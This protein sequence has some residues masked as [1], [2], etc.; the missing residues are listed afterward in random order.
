MSAIAGFILL[1]FSGVLLY[2]S[3][4]TL[5]LSFVVWIA[6]VP[7][8][9]VV[10]QKES[11]KGFI[12]SLFSGMIFFIGIFSW[13][14]EVPGYTY[15]HHA[16]LAVYLGS[17]IGI[18]G[19]VFSLINRRIGLIAA[20]FAAPF[21]W[22]ALEFIRSNFTFLALPWGLL[23]HSQ[24]KNPI[25]YQIASIT[26]TYGVSFLIVMVN[27]AIAALVLAFI[28][29]LKKHYS[30]SYGRR[31]KR[32][33]YAITGVGF[34]CLLLTCVYGYISVNQSFA[35]TPIKLAVVQGNI[36]QRKKWDRNYSKFIMQTYRDL[37][38]SAASKSPMMIVWPETATPGSISRHRGMYNKLKLMAA[39]ADAYLLF[40]SAQRA[41]F[42][43]H[44]TDKLKYTNSAFLIPPEKRK[45][46][47]QRYDKIRLFPFGEYLPYEETLPWSWINVPKMGAYV[48]GE[49]Y[50]ILKLD[51]VPF[52]ATICWE[53]MFSDLVRRFV[54]NGAQFIVN[55]TNEAWFGETAAPEQ[56]LSMNVF[57]AVEN[58]VYVVRSANTGI[59]CI[60]DPC[61]R[62]ID[63]V[64]DKNGKDIFV[65]GFLTSEVIPLESNTIY[66][67]Y[68][69]WFA[70]FCM[71]CSAAF[72]L[73]AFFRKT[74]SSNSAA[75]RLK[76]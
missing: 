36:A 14:L 34:F 64:K 38:L 30:S 7:N 23:A 17:Y 53:N 29:D 54:K 76:E 33:K 61:G 8:L 27:A 1:I 45:E 50:T 12:F 22:T 31:L 10:S 13:I 18:F 72:V 26:G 56:F 69:D 35:G 46:K 5:N 44:K 52:A 9:I 16:L 28:P 43:R 21:V 42:E 68:G 58:R 57:R 37:T 3:F 39:E 32:W 67:R 25:V 4:P 15:L 2:I 20:L 19:F 66:T 41:K 60:I 74:V 48:P 75:G 62:V 73:F 63:R 70:W 11:W 51:G 24:Y 47:T 6:L 49:E 71:A 40:G 65:S 55:M 59:S